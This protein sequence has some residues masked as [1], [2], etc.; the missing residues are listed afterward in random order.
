MVA[1]GPNYGWLTTYAGFLSEEPAEIR[2][3]LEL[4]VRDAGAG[5]MAAWDEAISLVRDAIGKTVV[6]LP[7]SGSNAVVFEYELP[8][9]GGR[10][11][12]VVILKS[13]SVVVVEFKGFDLPRRADIDQVAAYAR[14]LRNYHEGSHDLQ[15]LPVLVPT[16]FSGM[17]HRIDDVEVVPPA[18]LAG[19]MTELSQDPTGIAIDEHAWT[20]ADYAPLPS[21]IQAAREI[22]H[23]RPLPFIK[24]ANSTGIPQALSMLVQT[25]HRAAAD[26]TRHLVLLTGV[27]GAGK[28]LVGLQ[29]VHHHGI[30]D[31]VV[32][33]AGRA[34]GAPAVFLSGNGPLVAVLRHA[35]QGKSGEEKVFVQGIKNYLK[36]YA[37]RKKPSVPPEHILVFDEAQRAWDATR[38]EKKHGIEASEPEIVVRLAS[39]IPE[40]SMVLGLVGEGQEIHQGE[41]AGLAQ[42]ADAIVKSQE[43]ARWMVHGPEKLA[44]TFKSR[45]IP[46]EPSPSLDLTVTL[47]SH[48]SSG[49]HRWVSELL[50]AKDEDADNIAKVADSIRHDG[51]FMYL[52][53]DIGEAADYVRRRYEGQTEQRYGLIASSRAKNL[54]PL[55]IDNTFQATKRLKEGP[56]YNDPPNSPFSCCALQTVATEFQSQGLELDLPIVCWGD[57]LYREGGRWIV[58]KRKL[59][60]GYRNPDQ[61]RLNSYRVLLTR[62][63]DG[64]IV[65]VPPDHGD[66]M[67]DTA[68][69]LGRCGLRSLKD[70]S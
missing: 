66:G 45:S 67:D 54:E 47:R 6:I 20:Q 9:E 11:P 36:Q 10:R 27:P 33:S 65:Y 22:F 40:W 70:P 38:I 37:V 3:S 63:R 43:R 26:R 44:E 18:G 1:R 34:S 31:L 28:T 49:V 68:E 39:S 60:E 69:F 51:F 52:T 42:W 53:R 8:R 62:G 24:R 19:F 57:D 29:F 7:D 21:L 13:G 41:E 17:R 15:V 25:A 14:D 64:F 59:Q 23:N 61:L 35:L 48:L 16:R 32:P 50:N 30:D 58:A 4:F 2:H 56:W 12:D 46:F 55:G 5:Q